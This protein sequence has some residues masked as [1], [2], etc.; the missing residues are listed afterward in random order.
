VAYQACRD[1]REALEECKVAPFSW[2]W[3][4]V[5]TEADLRFARRIE[6]LRSSLPDIH[7]HDDFSFP[8]SARRSF[9]LLIMCA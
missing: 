2:S 5:E 9:P 3:H 4:I 1:Y 6:E 7:N 8:K